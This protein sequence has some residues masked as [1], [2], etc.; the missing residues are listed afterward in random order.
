MAKSFHIV[1]DVGILFDIRIGLRNIGFRLVVVIIRNEIAHRIVWHELT[2]LGAQLRCQRFIRFD[3]QRRALQTFNKPCCG[4]GFASSSGTHE[5]HIAFTVFNAFRKL[6]N[7]LRLVAA[8]LIR[9]F[10]HKRLVRAFN[11]ESHAYLAS[12]RH[13]F[14]S[15][16]IC[17]NICSNG[18]VESMIS[19]AM[20]RRCSALD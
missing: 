10:D 4:G 13:C 18:C 15:I 2:E 1:I 17:S 3:N 12:V 7:R 8:R 5:H 16:S 19:S 11:I 9:R 14:I 6:F 20:A